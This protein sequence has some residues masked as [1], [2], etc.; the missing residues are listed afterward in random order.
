[1]LSLGHPIWALGAVTI[2]GLVAAAIARFLPYYRR[3]ADSSARRLAQLDGLRGF[4][5]FGV[6][7]HHASLTHNL[8]T[9]NMWAPPPNQLYIYLGRGCVSL[10]FMA[11]G[12]LFWTRAIDKGIDAQRLLVSR[13]WRLMPLYWTTVIVVFGAA[14]WATH[15]KLQVDPIYFRREVAFWLT[16]GFFTAPTINGIYAVIFNAG[17]AWSLLYEWW[18]YF[19]LPMMAFFAPWRRFALG[20][21]A[22]FVLR[23]LTPT[24]FPEY[25]VGFDVCTGF[26]FGMLSAYLV[27]S[28]RLCHRMT[29]R[30]VAVGVVAVIA[31]GLVYN[32]RHPLDP[33]C[34]EYM[35]FPLFLAV[36]CG[37][38]I[39]GIL[40]RRW[41]QLMGHVS[42]SIYLVHGIVLYFL[43]NRGLGAQAVQQMTVQKY[44][45]WMV[46]AVGPAVVVVSAI[47][48][49]FVEAPFLARASLSL[50]R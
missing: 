18:F 40:T 14:G 13:F 11:S 4:L 48:Y 36:V 15:W 28:V 19:A 26:A 27:R 29:S 23:H 50:K 25:F 34:Y 7:I 39:W 44:W 2:A 33:I 47:T 5:A 42:Y 49:R 43:V 22:F 16:G 9:A 46:L 8:L 30:T 10:F 24:Y 20:L 35:S 41:S 3:L 6:F 1:M 37:N 32:Q 45:G 38:S 17:V 31:A 21:T 12:F